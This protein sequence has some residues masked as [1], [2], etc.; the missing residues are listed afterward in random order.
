MQLRARGMWRNKNRAA[1]IPEV[2]VDRGEGSNPY[3]EF[4]I[5]SSRLSGE[6]TVGDREE[7]PGE[8]G[9][10]GTLHG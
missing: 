6:L 7:I 10:Q 9:S 5:L 8:E 2:K 4:E 3:Q 1:K